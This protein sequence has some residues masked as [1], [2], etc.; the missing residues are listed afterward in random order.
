MGELFVSAAQLAELPTTGA[1]WDEL[2]D[3]AT[4]ALGTPSLLDSSQYISGRVVARGLAWAR[5]GTGGST[6][7]SAVI[8][9]C[10]ALA[11][12]S[13]AYDSRAM[14]RALAGYVI[15]A[16]LVDMP[17]DTPMTHQPGTTWDAWTR[18]A[19]TGAWGSD[20]AWPSVYAGAAAPHHEGG[21]ARAS[22]A[23]LAAYHGLAD[24]LGRCY[25]ILSRYVGN[26]DRPNPF[27][28]P[29]ADGKAGGWWCA[30]GFDAAAAAH[31]LAAQGVINPDCST[32]KG[33]VNVE[34]AARGGGPSVITG[35]GVLY[36]LGAAEG[37]LAAAI[38]LARHGYPQIW[39]DGANGLRRAATRL[40]VDAAVSTWLAQHRGI[41]YLIN[42]V[43]GAGTIATPTAG[44]IGNSRLLQ[45]VDWLTLGS[46]DTSW[47][48]PAEGI[49]TPPTA[50]LSLAATGTD[51]EVRATFN[52]ST[53]GTYPIAG[54]RVD[55]GDGTTSTVVTPGTTADHQY[56]TAGV[57]TVSVVAY[58]DRTPAND[59]DPQVRTF[60]LQVD[61]PPVAVLT[62][63]SPVSGVAPLT[64]TY[65]LS[66][67][68]DPQGS[69]LT[70]RIDWG[71][72]T[73]TTAAAA[74]GSH[75]YAAQASYPAT[76]TFSATVTSNGLESA[77]VVAAVTVLDPASTPT[78]SLAVW[79]GVAWVPIT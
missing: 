39:G 58:D 47:P 53:A 3:H 78:A 11:G 59:S 70:R 33:G 57:K 67:S 61:Q 20:P 27:T 54:H 17:R 45:G 42:Q 12:T 50:S 16:D 24:D 74:T 56:A 49:V 21:Y 55:W 51:R 41:P 73:I 79:N 52:A 30:T 46:A 35:N 19:V 34:D 64:V 15:A 69:A 1:E 6:S 48:A 60:A 32:A 65:D 37:N 9:A 72:G 31:Y 29:T 2:V 36:S 76:F 28:A 22:Y 77:P 10:A 23:A 66:G 8:S 4:P 63:L 75:Q 62:S 40:A 14:F 38:I 68:Y 5:N 44:T 71:D 43:Y 25:A 26:T 18:A 13:N 7:R